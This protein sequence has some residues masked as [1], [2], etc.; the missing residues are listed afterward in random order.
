MGTFFDLINQRESCRNYADKPVEKEKL[1]AC[2][3]AARIAPSACN[4]QPWSYVVVNNRVLSSKV[5]K[6]LQGAGMNKFTDQCPA[7]IV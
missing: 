3:E 7:F 5:A 4:S 1:I 2:V 6:C